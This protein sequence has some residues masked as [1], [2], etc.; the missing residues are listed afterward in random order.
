MRFEDVSYGELLVLSR[1]LVAYQRILAIR[2]STSCRIELEIVNE[3]LNEIGFVRQDQ[4]S[5]KKDAIDI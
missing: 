5:G 3:L 1:S 2:H 4:T